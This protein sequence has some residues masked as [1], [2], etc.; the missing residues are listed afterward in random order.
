VR[1]LKALAIILAAGISFLCQGAFARSLES[2]PNDSR[3]EANFLQV[4][5][6]R[7][8]KILGKINPLRDLDFFK[9]T[10]PSFSGTAILSITMTP[11]S[12]DHS[13]DATLQLLDANGNLLLKS[14]DGSD[15]EAETVTFQV[16]SETTYFAVC[17]S[18]DFL[19]AGSGD[20]SLEVKLHIPGPNLAPFQPPGWP[21]KIV[22]SSIPGT[23]SND[24]NL[25]STNV[26]YLD[27]A[28]SNNG[29]LPVNTTFSVSLHIDG[30][31]QKS[32]PIDPPINPDVSVKVQDFAIGPLGPGNH[33]ITIT[34]D[35]TGAIAE[36]DETD[37]QYT[38]VI[39]VID[40]DPDDQIREAVPLGQANS[41]LRSH[42]SIDAPADVDIFSVAVSA[43]Q[44]LSISLDQV[45]PFVGYVRLL[46]S[47]G[48]EVDA[49]STSLE[50]TFSEAGAYFIGVSGVGNAQYDPLTAAGK[51]PGSTGAY[52]LIISP[53]IAGTIQKPDDS[54]QY[55]VDILRFGERPLAI[56]PTQKTWIMIHGWNSS[57]T[58]ENIHTAAEALFRTRPLDQVLTLDW[59]SAAD[60]G[61]LNP[62]SAESSIVPV[63][64]WA[65]AALAEYGFAGT[66][67]NL[68]G[69]SFGSY[70]ADELAKRIPGGVNT[71]VTLDPA[72]DVPGGFSPVAN[73]EVDFGR[74]SFFS[75]SF[76]SSSLGNDY[77][78]ATADEAFIV[79][80]D[81]N[82]ID[83]HGNVVFLFAYMLLNPT[84]P[85]S[86]YFLL[87]SLLAGTFGP[88][89]P[90]QY[91]SSFFGDQGIKG[92]EAVID[93][94]NGGL[95]PAGITY[96]PLPAL[97]IT[98]QSDGIS[99]TW[100][101][102]YTGFV[103]QSSPA[104]SELSWTDFPAQPIVAGE[105]K[106][107]SL[108]PT[109]QNQLFRLIKR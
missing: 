87:S 88:W 94:S 5:P 18:A 4:D 100:P 8:F 75:W 76:H 95:K 27:W 90:D 45:A 33:S 14:D 62:F 20:Y 35:S 52:T 44:R 53:G 21:E 69:H 10:T 103:L 43:G 81:A 25:I 66:N 93:T 86:Q 71:I 50:H 67:L 73:D 12:S 56:D 92:Y 11:T 9:L 61:V 38:K 55:L 39:T 26:L 91:T 58:N 106:V 28:A 41:T 15:N 6:S 74:D 102:S 68:V 96:V 22:V 7:P 80:S 77:V 84:D 19:E 104:A 24:G 83:A 23:S 40:D 17:G 98:K 16:N 3:T 97:G 51:S 72:A 78:P 37:N 1:T 48:Q 107:V 109:E 99:I 13:L 42:G 30:V 64:E 57:R 101:A 82:A 47:N 79:D 65:A 46:T 36:S 29:E 89:L 2:E 31:L 105:S 60:T 32:W 108:S 49:S 59:S 70:V 85:V 54:T 34:A 63:A